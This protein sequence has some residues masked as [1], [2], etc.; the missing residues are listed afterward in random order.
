MDYYNELMMQSNG[1]GYTHLHPFKK[2]KK[3]LLLV[4]DPIRDLLIEEGIDNMDQW[5][6]TK[7]NIERARQH[8]IHAFHMSAWYP[9]E[10]DSALSTLTA[11]SFL[12]DWDSLNTDLGLVEA[13]KKA[14]DAK[15]FPAFVRLDSVSPKYLR[16]VY[17]VQEAKR[18]IEASGR[19]QSAI[20][21]ARHYGF[22]IYLVLRS[23]QDYSRGYEYRAFVYKDKVTAICL[24]DEKAPSSHIP[25][26]EIIRRVCRIIQACQH[27]QP[28]MNCVADIFISDVSDEQDQLIE[29]N[30]F[31]AWANASSGLFHWIEDEWELHDSKVINIR[32]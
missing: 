9:E 27:C 18:I 6:Y 14:V 21:T 30:S 1:G 20:E 11:R 26:T 13:Q 31:G 8:Y 3:G 5:K 24:N 19:C 22:K 12:F 4:P 32:K 15:I 2:S 10:D 29:Y 16:P 7:Q 25:D 28:F 17:S 23:Y